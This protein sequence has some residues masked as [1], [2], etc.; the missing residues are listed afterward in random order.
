MVAAGVYLVGRMFAVFVHAD[1][2]VLTFVSIIAAITML[3]AAL[4]AM[5]QDDI[6]R[7]LAYSTVSQLAYMVAGLSLGEAGYTA[8][9]FHLFTHGFFKALL[10][11]GAGSV[12]HA[13]HHEQDMRK[14]GGLWRK[15]PV[16]YGLMWIGSL[17]LVGFGIPGVTGFAGF[18]SKDIVIEAAYAAQ[19]AAGGFAFWLGILAALMTAFYS[20][21]L[22]FMTFHG[23]PA[24]RHAYDH[25]HESPRVMTWPLIVLALAVTGGDELGRPLAVAVGAASLLLAWATKVW[26]EDPVR[27]H[28][29]VRGGRGA[30]AAAVSGVLVV[31]AVGATL[32]VRVDRVH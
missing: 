17:S 29:L 7:V 3:I 22:L 14:M 11:L 13:M 28:R 1:P 26:V 18:Y 10:F 2:F 25:A 4:L 15:I 12:I 30:L 32:D 6:K 21:R 8:G 19:S 16:T 20:F 23:E 31:A 27:D 9:L 24:D 5:I